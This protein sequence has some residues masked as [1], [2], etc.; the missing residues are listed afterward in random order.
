LLNRSLSAVFIFSLI[1]IVFFSCGKTE[2]KIQDS[3]IYNVSVPYKSYH[4]I[5]GVTKEEIAGIEALKS[6]K[7]SFSYGTIL[8][9]EFFI[10]EDGAY[11]GF[12]H[13]FAEH[14]SNLFDIPF[15]VKLLDWDDLINSTDNL[16]IDFISELTPTVERKQKYFM[17]TAIAERTLSVFLDND[18]DG[19]ETTYNLNGLNIGFFNGTITEQ[20][21]K[22]TYPELNFNSVYIDTVF[23]AAQM[24]WNKEVD[25]V[26][27]DEPSDYE[28]SIYGNIK[29][30]KILPL[31]YTPISL[32]TAN[33][34]LEPVIS[35]LD[36]YLVK[37]GLDKIHSLYTQGERSYA[38]FIFDLSLTEEEKAY[39]ADLK[40]NGK[41]VPVT[42]E[43]DNYPLC[44]YD[45]KTH[46]F[47][48]IAVDIIK[49]I[50]FLTD[51]EFETVTNKNTTMVEI[52]E[53]IKSGGAAFDAELI[54][55]KARENDFLFPHSPYFTSNFALLSKMDYPD[56]KIYQVAKAV[57][58]IV[59]G[60]APAE[61]LQLLIPGNSVYKEY[62]TRNDALDALEKGEIDL[63]L[64]TDYIILYQTHF[65]E[66]TGYKINLLFNSITER[67]FFGFNKNEEILCSIIEK[68][69]S[70][71]DINKIV[72]NWTNRVY[73]YSKKITSDRFF[74]ML[75][76][77]AVLSVLLVIFILLL[78]KYNK[79]IIKIDRQKELFNIV[80]QVS[81]VLLEPEPQL[82]LQSYK[83]HF[84]ESIN[85]SM[86][87]LAKAINVDRICIW[88]NKDK[89]KNRL[90]FYLG[91][92]WERGIF[93]SHSKK[94]EL[95]P[96]LYFD[97]HPVW[98]NIL[99]QGNC[100]N[101]NVCDM[102]P[103]EQAELKPRN[104]LSLF[105]VPVFFH[106][107]L[108]GFVGFDNC[109]KERIIADNEV[110][111]LRSAS[112]M[113]A[114]TVIR[115]DMTEQLEIAKDQAEQSNRSKSIFLSHMSHEIRTPMNAILGIAEIQLQKETLKFDRVVSADEESFQDISEAF[116][117]I[118]ESGNLL[119]NIINDIL[120]LS[121]IESGKLEIFPIKYDIPS[122]IN[123][124]VQ[125][126]RLRYESKPIEFSL[127]ISENMP[128]DLI[129][130][131]LRI[132]QVLN[133]ILSNAF[134]YTD[135]GKIEFFV[136]VEPDRFQKD[137][138]TLI[139]RVSDTGQ[140]M[141]E[142]QLSRI[143]EEYT[144][145]NIEINRTTVGAGLGMSISKR[146][147]ELMNGEIYIES[148][149]GKG[150]VFTVRIPQK[151][152]G[153][154]IINREL[155]S[156]LKTFNFH[157][158]II[159][160]K[161]QFLREYMPY[162]SV[163]VVDDVESNI[164]V[165]KG[166]MIPYGLKIDTASSGFE[167]IRKIEENNVYDIIFM[168]HMMPK[169][170]GIETV[171]IIREKG[172][173]YPII[174]LTANALVGRK[175]MFLQ[176]GFDSFIS[177][178]IDSRELDFILIEF[179]KNKKPEEVVEAARR[180]SVAERAALQ[181]EAWNI[182]DTKAF[183]IIDF[184]IRDAENAVKVLENI[185]LNDNE[186][187]AYIT[188]IHG[189]KSALANI[190]EKEFSLIAS[191]LEEAGRN[192]NYELLSN[193]T[194]AFINTLKNLIENFKTSD[195]NNHE[196]VSDNDSDIEINQALLNEKLKEIKNACSVYDKK[197]AKAA[198][199]VLKKE[200]LS[201]TIK[202][203]LNDIS[204]HL[205]HSEF[206]EIEELIFQ[207]IK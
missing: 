26:I 76:F 35:V 50:T 174:A 173:N 39:L 41:K 113:I 129:G 74:Y 163:L 149:P 68:A 28:F 186:I 13:L 151:R 157:S 159:T 91:F 63:F 138:V 164:Y 57:V 177:K 184:F 120:D 202:K 89:E 109:C 100:I 22:N 117:K 152:A 197:T 67:S 200:N 178:P 64:T 72:T 104:I 147:I 189:I 205:L 53:I 94:D 150:S 37:D 203:L 32:S 185:N 110:L 134:K 48:G 166:M 168:D 49:E 170:D 156:K 42:M 98:N 75:I 54:H 3:T 123:D 116:E 8:A 99:S 103:K 204:V 5:P 92:Q 88:I 183:R 2:K 45:D 6:T 130:D 190:G 193:A 187:N 1:I 191:K 181:R 93:K 87:I 7:K 112:R 165:A 107:S 133:N 62:R 140:G 77:I 96:D 95:A 90:C 128:L 167:A 154:E 207:Y 34:A 137:N 176:N 56:L 15:E 111:I 11:S 16:S 52:L 84:E 135:Q 10:L 17:T 115:N 59:T 172:Y 136:S 43:A 108:W 19:I 144:R 86:G 44:F 18:T 4:E 38:Q 55:T 114:N 206:T 180:V 82:D 121:K 69:S 195:N 179:I 33:P 201:G 101:S 158:S 12:I 78:F 125:I 14:L 60:T 145:F 182:T 23:N 169:M 105:V 80:N 171:K 161:V 122:F 175:K 153:N 47:H 73:D 36:K 81:S 102:S 141:T 132:R 40:E 124:T 31:V 46:D 119:L 24:L 146:L 97:E 106:D 155:I 196:K 79:M 58:G 51:I 126:N 61:M 142:E 143:F 25:A 192:R 162:G 139:F 199:D 30:V 9:T 29:S 70:K 118:Y 85:Q 160:K 20:S 27:I 83:D 148:V 21:I 131:V 127:H 71:I 188:A 194:P 198:L 65:R 66:K